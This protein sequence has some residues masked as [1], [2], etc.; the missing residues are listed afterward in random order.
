MNVQHN[1]VTFCR[2]PKEGSGEQIE[3]WASN[4]EKL[5]DVLERV[6]YD[7]HKQH[8]WI[9]NGAKNHCGSSGCAL[10]WACMSDEFP[11]LQYT[12]DP[13]NPNTY[14]PTINGLVPDDPDVYEWAM[15]G[16]TFFG[17]AVTDTLFSNSSWEKDDLI[18]YLRGFAKAY[19]NNEEW[20]YAAMVD[21]VDDD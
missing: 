5:A 11:G 19:R 20:E 10:G 21:N 8:T 17:D 1:R 12:Y 14:R 18:K 16:S 15:A 7:K 3:F 13:R 9:R 2:L 4:C 6:P